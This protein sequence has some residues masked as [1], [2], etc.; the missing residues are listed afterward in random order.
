MAAKEKVVD[1]PQQCQRQR[2]RW[3]WWGRGKCGEGRCGDSKATATM[4]TIL[5]KLQRK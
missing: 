3:M 2:Q 1:G 5:S 4:S